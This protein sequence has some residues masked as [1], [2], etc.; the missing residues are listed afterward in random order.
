[1]AVNPLVWPLLLAVLQI[2]P[3]SSETPTVVVVVGAP[4]TPEYRRQFAACAR[5]WEDAARR[6]GARVITLGATSPADSLAAS[7]TL[8]SAAWIADFLPHRSEWSDRLRRLFHRLSAPAPSPIIPAESSPNMPGTAVL[9]EG[10]ERPADATPARTR[11]SSTD[12]QHLRRTLENQPK[13]GTAPLWL[14]LIG[15][16]TF[17]GRTARFNLRGPDLSAQTLA[18]WLSPF[19]RPL[20]VINGASCSGPFVPALSAPGRIVI[21]ATRSGYERNAT[22]FAVYIAQAVSDP[23][24]DLDKD[25]QVS[26]LEAFLAASRRTQE[27]YESQ[28]RLATEHALLEDNADGRG[29]AATAYADKPLVE[30]LNTESIDGRTAH[31][32]TL[33]ASPE[34]QRL[35]PAFRRRRAELEAQLDELKRLK[36]DLGADEY[37]RRLERL[38][39]ELAELYERAGALP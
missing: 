4:G 14:V 5:Q 33:I 26:L 25:R 16:G 12:R 22:R 38:L 21:T 36:A 29:I 6:G 31:R 20:V 23:Q 10:V 35:S 19:D 30:V 17:D 11:I 28:G 39:V 7:E 1:M 2:Q 32:I 27:S 8:I 15:H 24:A 37:R 9:T 18:E 34:E 13:Q 3:A